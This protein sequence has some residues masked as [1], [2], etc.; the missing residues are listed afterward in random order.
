MMSPSRVDL[1]DAAGGPL[2]PE[3]RQAMAEWLDRA[4]NP[5]SIHG[6]GRQAK[7]ALDQ[8]RRHV[9]GLI[10]AR[11]EEIVF[12]SCG[13]ESNNW[14]IRGLLAANKRK[15]NHL[16]VSSIEHPSVLLPAKRLE[17]EGWDVTFLPVSGEGLIEPSSLRA[18]LTSTTALVSIMHANG[19]IGTIEPIAELAALAHEAG[20]LFHTDAVASAGHVELDVTALGVDALSLAATGFYG[21]S[22]AAALFVRSGVRILP[23]LEGGGQEMGSRS[24]TEALPNLVGMGAAAEAATA[25]LVEWAAHAQGLRDRLKEGLA[26]RIEEIRFMGSWSSRLPHNLHCCIPGLGSESLVLGLDQ[27]GIRVGIGSACNSKAM[28]PSHVLQA[29][30]IPEEEAQG[31]LLLTLGL[32][33]TQ[34]QIDQAIEVVPALV[35]RLRQVTSVTI[36]T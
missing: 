17:R 15:G 32:Q 6:A 33:T 21:P 27:E 25:H 19:E 2:L 36:R 22:G 8:A 28:R 29:I 10:R 9:A 4:G 5:S 34:A 14:A 12:T 3:A 13:T 31:A 26:G 11:P 23:L 18:A 20:A 30:G 7:R 35:T 24:G 1:D 16:I